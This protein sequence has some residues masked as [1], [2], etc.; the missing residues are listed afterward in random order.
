[1]LPVFIP[2]LF[3]RCKRLKIKTV[4]VYPKATLHIEEM[5]KVIIELEKKDLHIM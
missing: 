5:V 3:R 2:M 1:M 4:S